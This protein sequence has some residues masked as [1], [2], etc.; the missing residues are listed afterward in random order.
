M[1]NAEKR[2][3][4]PAAEVDPASRGVPPARRS[5]VAGAPGSPVGGVAVAAIED[6]RRNIIAWV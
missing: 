3:N 5:Q 4:Q 1:E 6:D 2:L